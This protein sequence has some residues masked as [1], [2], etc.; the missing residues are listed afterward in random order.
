MVEEPLG[1]RKARPEG[2]LVLFLE[3]VKKILSW[4]RV[5]EGHLS[6]GLTQHPELL[7]SACL[8]P[9]EA[10]SPGSRPLPSSSLALPRGG[11]AI[12]GLHLGRPGR[13][14]EERDTPLAAPS[15]SPLG[16]STPQSV[17]ALGRGMLSPPTVPF[18]RSHCHCSWLSN[19]HLLTG[20]SSGGWRGPPMSLLQDTNPM[21]P[22]GH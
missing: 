17:Q 20:P 1:S 22:S 14:S 19:G 12:L 3:K 21:A 2:A 9:G 16:V 10:P 5:W 7:W 4:A 8:A 18:N 11:P 15:P 6:P 13:A